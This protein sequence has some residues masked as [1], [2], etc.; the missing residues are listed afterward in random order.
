MAR[1]LTE[2]SVEKLT[3]PKNK[4]YEI[5]DAV[6]TGLLIKIT[7]RA[8][9]IWMARLTYPGNRSQAKRAL[10]YYPEMGVAEARAKAQRWHGWVRDGKDPA[11]VE[12]AEREKLETARRA[13]AL[14]RQNTFEAYAEQ[15]IKDRAG[16]RRA[17]IDE[18]EIRRGLISAWADKPLHRI[19]PR[20]VRQRIEEIRLKSGPYEAL[21]CWGHA[22]QIFKQAVHDE[23]IE[24]APTASLNKKL[25]FRGAKIGPRLT[26]LDDL[27]L[28]ALW[29]G[30]RR[31]QYPYRQFYELSVLLGT[32]VSEM[33]GARWSEFHPEIRKR[34]RDA[35]KAEKSVDWR[36]VDDN[37]K[38]WTI[39][40]ER[41]KS[42]AQ[43]LVPLPDFALSILETLPRMS[44]SDLLFTTTG[45]IPINGFSV[46]K[47]RLDQYMERALK[48]FARRNGDDPGRVKLKDW[49]NHDL[50]RC[51]RSGLS[52]LGIEDHVAELCI[53]HSRRGLQK[54]Y[55]QH[56]YQSAMFDA[57]TR[58]S[59]RVQTIVSPPPKPTPANVVTLRPKRKARR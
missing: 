7:P 9:K 2:K 40:R 46:A 55:D 39:P 18:R 53:G 26:V 34:I 42:D 37:V 35:A 6:A 21:H 14:K 59:E 25:L 51:L 22:T 43:H 10:G 48:A 45:E 20:D 16:N 3:I 27:E 19:A 32:R 31:L 23:L 5:Y 49:V 56:K 1:R 36:T 24:V 47:N 28:A 44:G 54:I 50:R 58:W 52:A 41:F 11:E 17:A 8:R 4:H 13:E 12:E 57:L 33:A 15:F 38:T 29:R 30:A